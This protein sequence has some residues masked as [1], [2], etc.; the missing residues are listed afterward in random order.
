MDSCGRGYVCSHSRKSDPEAS[1]YQ[2]SANDTILKNTQVRPEEGRPGD[3]PWDAGVCGGTTRGRR[4]HVSAAREMTS[5]LCVWPPMGAGCFWTWERHVLGRFVT[6]V[7]FG[8]R[9]WWMG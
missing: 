2:A 5:R 8:F 1:R 7:W 3:P 9:C 4:L 6:A